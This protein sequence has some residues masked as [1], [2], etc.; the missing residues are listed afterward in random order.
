MSDEIAIPIHGRT[1]LRSLKLFPMSNAWFE[2]V[3][4]VE[5][6]ARAE[7]EWQIRENDE[8]EYELN[9]D[10]AFAP[11][12]AISASRDPCRGRIRPGSLVGRLSLEVV[13][14][15]TGEHYGRV[16]LEVT[17]RKMGYRD[18]YQ[19][20]LND[21]ARRATDLVF[22]AD[23][24]VEQTVT[25]DAE[26]DS[27]TLYQRFA[28]LKAILESEVFNEAVL[29]VCS[30][31]IRALVDTESDRPV[32]RISRCSGAAV[33]QFATGV[34][35]IALPK[36]HVLAVK[37]GL[38][39]IPR[40]IRVTERVETCDV[41]ENQFVRYV[42]EAFADLLRQ[43]AA[44]ANA[45]GVVR[46]EAVALAERMEVY[47]SEPFFRGVSQLS[48][49]PLD[50]TALQRKEGYREIL[51]AWTLWDTAAK[52]SWKGGDDVYS[53]GKKDVASLYEYWC[54]FKLLDI[55]QGVFGITDTDAA[56][57]L[58]GPSSDGL[59]LSLKEGRKAVLHG[60]YAPRKEGCRYRQLKIEFMYNATFNKTHH[61]GSWTLPMRPDYTIAFSPEG[62]KREEALANDLVT[63][64]HFD[65]KYKVAEL[66]TLLKEMRDAEMDIPDEG[67]TREVKLKR[68]V[69]RMDIL[70][71]HAYRD[72]IRRTGGAYVLYPGDKAKPIRM[73][74]EILPGLGAF[75]LSP[76]VDSTEEITTF[77][78]EVAEH[79]CDRITRWENYTYRAHEIFAQGGKEFSEA[80]AEV[81]K[82]LVKGDE[83]ER[84]ERDGK[85]RNLTA[86]TSQRHAEADRYFAHPFPDP[87]YEQVKWA[88][89]K[90]LCVVQ[91]SK[92]NKPDP[93]DLVMITAPW[94][95][96]INML[97][98]RFAG[99]FTGAELKRVHPDCP[100]HLRH[101]EAY[102][103]WDVR[104]ID[105]CEIERYMRKQGDLED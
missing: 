72:A 20:M 57:E 27:A 13:F 14:K 64:V 79:L 90:G 31:P 23:Q 42:L 10:V 38:E 41:A 99:E 5:A 7:S 9:S 100:I 36:G 102:L 86:V 25:P 48:R 1:T 94:N 39:T 105:T 50:S 78:R 84:N 21:I 95:P 49:L 93:H 68:D 65:A 75:P 47:L 97:V 54:Y 101:D 34:D 81:E 4:S 104:I 82:Y 66:E 92:F 26:V 55:V 52:L 67:A 17:S 11:H 74:E 3:A 24:V 83:A 51:R 2:H 29:R 69:K 63:Y 8:Y 43:V 15:S 61:S 88:Y 35:R 32:T 85:R 56:K 46:R 6:D 44:L 18:D 53:A 12:P 76:T 62:M 33:R 40:T 80:R 30:N 71:M 60:K 103:L 91:A 70:K 89:F 28:F 19:Q 59:T 98:Q 96:P 45:E 16:E 22:S 73:Y 77:L 58:I 87:R 37:A